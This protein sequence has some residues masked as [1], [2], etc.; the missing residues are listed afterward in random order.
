MLAFFESQPAYNNTVYIK[1]HNG[2]NIYFAFPLLNKIFK[3]EMETNR[4]Q[5]KMKIYEMLHYQRIQTL[6]ATIVTWNT[7]VE[8]AIRQQMST[9]FNHCMVFVICMILQCMI[10]PDFDLCGKCEKNG[11]HSGRKCQHILYCLSI[12]V[13]FLYRT[14]H[15]SNNGSRNDGRSFNI[16]KNR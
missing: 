14:Y 3:Q 15:G 11:I 8:L 5:Q 12:S 13:L 1:S 2:I 16:Y 9:F 10:C 6:Y 7:F 4:N